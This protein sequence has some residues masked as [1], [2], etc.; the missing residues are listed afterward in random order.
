MKNEK[1][2]TVGK[3]IV[4]WEMQISST[5]GSRNCLPFRSTWIHPQFKKNI[6]GG[7][8]VVQCLISV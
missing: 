6:F 7:I 2:L 5:I 1:Y 8:C 4:Q 3:L